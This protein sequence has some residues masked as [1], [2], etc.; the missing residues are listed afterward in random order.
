MH[1]VSLIY[2]SCNKWF[3][4]NDKWL[5]KFKKVVV[6][7]LLEFV[8]SYNKSPDLDTY[9]TH[10]QEEGWSHREQNEAQMRNVVPIISYRCYLFNEMSSFKWEINIT[11]SKMDVQSIRV[12]IIV[13]KLCYYF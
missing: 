4:S 10:E 1:D 7:D 13:C 6:Y 12:H 5:S 3:H 9:V 8:G 11:S 2:W